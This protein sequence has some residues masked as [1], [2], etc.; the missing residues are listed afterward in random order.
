MKM[1]SAGMCGKDGGRWGGGEGEREGG[2]GITGVTVLKSQTRKIG[3]PYGNAKVL[4]QNN[5]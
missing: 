4:K 2:G 1:K 3:Y 5:I